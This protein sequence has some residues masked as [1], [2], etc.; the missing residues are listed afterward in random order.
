MANDIQS[1]ANRG[2]TTYNKENRKFGGAV[3]MEEIDT[4]NEATCD[5]SN[6]MHGSIKIDKDLPDSEKKILFGYA[7][8]IYNEYAK[9][10]NDGLTDRFNKAWDLI[11]PNWDYK[12]PDDGDDEYLRAYYVLSAMV[13]EELARKYQD[14]FG[15]YILL[16]P[17]ESCTIAGDFSEFW[18]NH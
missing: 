14:E 8:T 2:C 16:N 12:N 9:K 7:M 6:L 1:D 3:F 18:I 4:K 10:M 11:H 13:L 17:V 15:Y 5:Y